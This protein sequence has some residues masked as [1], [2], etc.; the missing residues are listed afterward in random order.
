MRP[1][2]CWFGR[3]GTLHGSATKTRWGLRMRSP[4]GLDLLLRRSKPLHESLEKAIRLV[5]IHHA[6]VDC[7]RHVTQRTNDDAIL[8]GVFGRHHHGP[9]FQLSNTQNCRLRLVDDD[10]SGKEAAAD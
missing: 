4:P 7:Q 9:L 1:E 5:A 6:M 8:T 2:P 10:R 3:T